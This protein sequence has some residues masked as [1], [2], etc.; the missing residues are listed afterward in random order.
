M[1]GMGPNRNWLWHQPSGLTAPLPRR[2]GADRERV[3]G[4]GEL[5]GQNPVHQTV[6]LDPALAFEG[7]GYDVDTKMCL[8]FRAMTGMADMEMR[9]V[10]HLQTVGRQ[11][12][13][14]L[15]LDLGLDGHAANDNCGEG[16]LNGASRLA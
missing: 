6:A 1:T 3:D 7:R 14:E 2:L 16:L 4:A 12:G 5:L 8:S 15:A 10:D 13:G 11:G 9:F